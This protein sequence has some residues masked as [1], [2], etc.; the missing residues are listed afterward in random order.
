M[1]HRPCLVA[2]VELLADL[3]PEPVEHLQ[4]PTGRLVTGLVGDDLQKRLEHVEVRGDH[5]VNQGSKDLHSDNP[6]VV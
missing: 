1:H 5:P 6:A 2:Q 3:L 4:Q